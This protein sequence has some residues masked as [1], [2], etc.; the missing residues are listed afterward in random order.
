MSVV[1][2]PKSGQR[3]LTTSMR[4]TGARD[5]RTTS[6]A[7]KCCLW[8]CVPAV[9]RPCCCTCCYTELACE[10]HSSSVRLPPDQFSLLELASSSRSQ[11]AV[12]DARAAVPPDLGNDRPSAFAG[13][14]RRRWRLLLGWRASR[15][16]NGYVR[17]RRLPMAGA[18]A[19]SRWLRRASPTTRTSTYTLPPSGSWLGGG[20]GAG[21]YGGVSVRPSQ[22]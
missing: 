15:V 11:V 20:H 2:R 17:R 7:S 9:A 4:T 12:W 18:I 14:L 21:T 6:A 1:W 8:S 13:V 19:M 3:G 22:A 16:R 10:S 5:Y